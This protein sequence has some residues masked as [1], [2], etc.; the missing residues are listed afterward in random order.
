MCINVIMYGNIR[1]WHD[2]IAF[3]YTPPPSPPPKKEGF[4]GL[5]IYR[6]REASSVSRM[7]QNGFGPSPK[8]ALFSFLMGVL[9]F[10]LF[11]GKMARVRY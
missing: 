11:S 6:E 1:M 3:S 7:G 5:D 8:R 2:S 10:I 9:S 4:L